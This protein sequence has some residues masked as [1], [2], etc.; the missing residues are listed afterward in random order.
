MH[1]GFVQQV[2]EIGR[3]FPDPVT[4]IAEQ[5]FAS[6]EQLVT[7]FQS[8]IQSADL[9]ARRE[10]QIESLSQSC[11]ELLEQARLHIERTGLCLLQ[12]SV[13]S[14]DLQQ[15]DTASDG[16]MP[17]N[18]R[19]ADRRK[20]SVDETAKKLLDGISEHETAPGCRSWVKENQSALIASAIVT[21]LA[22][23][24]FVLIR[25]NRT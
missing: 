9:L 11:R 12:F 24:T 25:R 2:F 21:L 20:E 5:L 6:P 1:C 8:E 18:K 3:R 17:S 7:G 22:V 14:P 23:G 10:K 16:S 19:N 13:G 4:V 15:G